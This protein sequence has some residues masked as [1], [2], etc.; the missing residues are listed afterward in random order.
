MS[1]CYL[2]APLKVRDIIRN[3]DGV[4][5]RNGLPFVKDTVEYETSTG[6]C[7]QTEL[8]LT[9]YMVDSTLVYAIQRPE[10]ARD[11]QRSNKMK[12]YRVKSGR[13]PK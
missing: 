4:P 1:A 5:A 13:E 8:G 11:G 9:S 12:N 3:L 6:K 10:T 2:H 7:S